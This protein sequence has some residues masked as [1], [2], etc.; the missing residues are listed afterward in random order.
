VTGVQTCALPIYSSDYAPTIIDLGVSFKMNAAG[1]YAI[2]VANAT[3]WIQV[4]D[5]RIKFL[6]G[7]PPKLPVQAGEGTPWEVLKDNECDER[8]ASGLERSG[9]FIYLGVENNYTKFRLNPLRAD[10]KLSVG[11]VVNYDVQMFVPSEVLAGSNYQ[12]I[13]V[14]AEINYTYTSRNNLMLRVTPDEFL[15][16]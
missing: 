11:D 1:G 9:N 4:V 6:C 16:A 2:E 14:E 13:L 8:E 12:G 5:P 7:N 15:D 3:L 10:K